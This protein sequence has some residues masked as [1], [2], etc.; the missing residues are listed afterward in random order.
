MA[1]RALTLFKT[2]DTGAGHGRVALDLENASSVTERLN[3]QG[4]VVGFII[5]V[6]GQ[7]HSVLSDGRALDDLVDAEELKAAKKPK[8]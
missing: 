8:A 6:E 7:A 4:A 2:I 1:A 5:V 3:A